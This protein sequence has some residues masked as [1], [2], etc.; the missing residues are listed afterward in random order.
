[1]INT[2]NK[3]PIYNVIFVR[4]KKLT[5]YKIYVKE[6]TITCE[7]ISDSSSRTAASLH[8][9]SSVCFDFVYLY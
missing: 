6:L 5:R 8:L 7:L 9:M 2:N 4:K 3:I 1:M